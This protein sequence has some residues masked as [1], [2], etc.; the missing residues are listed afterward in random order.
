MLNENTLER[1]TEM[2]ESLGNRAIRRKMGVA[3]DLLCWTPLAPMIRAS[4]RS[5]IE[6][7]SHEIRLREQARALCEDATREHADLLTPAWG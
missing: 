4:R 5:R 6:S 2:M 1:L 7:Q 3:A